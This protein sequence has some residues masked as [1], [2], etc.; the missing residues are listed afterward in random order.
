M[1]LYN[2][3][4]HG[5]IKKEMVVKLKQRKEEI[6]MLLPSVTNVNTNVYIPRINIVAIKQATAEFIKKY[7]KYKDNQVIKD[8]QIG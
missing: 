6:N 2:C 4:Y 8:K 5:N 1:R 3:Y 7:N